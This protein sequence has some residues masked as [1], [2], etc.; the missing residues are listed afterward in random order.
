MFAAT[1]GPVGVVR[2]LLQAGAAVNTAAQD[3]STCLIA[4]CSRWCCS[5]QW[6]EEAAAVVLQLLAAGA[7][8]H[9][10]DE[11]GVSALMAAANAGSVEGVDALLKAGA[12][13]NAATQHGDTALHCAVGAFIGEQPAV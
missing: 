12:A 7:N 11:Q 9:A 1:S 4:A 3:G 6:C 2:S 10:A 5:D 13:V 8:V